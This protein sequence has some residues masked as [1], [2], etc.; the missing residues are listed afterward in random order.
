M[1]EEFE[2][3]GPPRFA[4]LGQGSLQRR[5]TG[6][7]LGCARSAPTTRKEPGGTGDLGTRG[8]RPRE[9]NQAKGMKPK[10]YSRDPRRAQPGRQPRNPQPRDSTDHGA[11]GRPHPPAAA[12][13]R[14]ESGG[15]GLFLPGQGPEPAG[16]SA[17]PGAHSPSSTCSV[18]S[19]SAPLPSAGPTAHFRF[20]GCAPHIRRKCVRPG[21]EGRRARGARR[22][23]RGAG[24]PTPEVPRDPGPR[25]Q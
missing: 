5:I 8:R 23:P 3:S 1:G 15:G 11:R 16:N 18:N 21:E 25:A 4:P 17:R 9:E 14:D 13:P 10:R 22:E 12:A 19:F 6:C 7:T 2:R 20:R 24:A